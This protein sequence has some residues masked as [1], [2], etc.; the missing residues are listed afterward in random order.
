FAMVAHLVNT[1]FLL[2]AITLTGWWASGGR[3]VRVRGSGAVGGLLGAGVLG[4]VAVGA[5]GAV[6]ALGD[7][8]FPAAS[9]AEGFRQDFSPTAH[10]LLRLRVLH[11]VLAVGVGAYLLV[12]GRIV[13]RLRPSAATRRLA[14]LLAALFAAQLGAGVLNVVLLVPIWMQLVHLLMADLV[15][16]SLVLL[17][18]SA[19][20]EPVTGAQPARAVREE[21][22]AL[23]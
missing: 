20:A 3:E 16:I 18:A 13:A 11:P 14:T 23:A 10:F 21:T 12:A 9:L 22:P 7:T 5:T 4:V 8:L 1:F 19:L 17:S 6:A 15:W 2:A